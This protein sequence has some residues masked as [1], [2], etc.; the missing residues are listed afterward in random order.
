MITVKLFRKVGI[1]CIRGQLW[2][3]GEFLGFKRRLFVKVILLLVFVNCRF[4][5]GGFFEISL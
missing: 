4:R 5:L 1:R 3:K 2:F